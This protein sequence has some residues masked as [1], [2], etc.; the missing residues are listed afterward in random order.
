MA[1]NT[2]LHKLK[3][4]RSNDFTLGAVAPPRRDRGDSATEIRRHRQYFG[5]MLHEW[6]TVETDEGKIKRLQ[7]RFSRLDLESRLRLFDTY[8]SKLETHI[9]SGETEKAAVLQTFIEKI[10]AGLN[11]K[12]SS[13][14]DTSMGLSDATISHTNG[15]QETL[16]ENAPENQGFQ[17]RAKRGSKGISAAARRIIKSCGVIL[18]E[19]FRRPNLSLGTCTTPPVDETRQRQLCENWSEIKRQFFQALTRLLASRG[20]STDYVQVTEIQEKRFEKWGQVCP[21]LHF[22]FQ[23]RLHS[24][25]PWRVAPADIQ[26]LWQRSMENVL[27]VRLDCRSATRIENPR[28]SLSKE[29]GKYLT[30]G[31]K[32]V[33]EILDRGLGAYLPSSWYGASKALS[34]LERAA[35]IERTGEIATYVLRNLEALAESG[36]IKFRR[37]YARFKCPQTGIER[38]I[39]VGA[40]GWFTSRDAVNRVLALQFPTVRAVA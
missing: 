16:I 11:D 31:G 19:R 15:Q 4:S 5:W 35:R 7:S 27:G 1:T 8:E 20:L 2:K 34:L 36:E 29:L 9:N 39:C 12:D 13:E 32:V 28:K 22:V 30:K 40:S 14:V 6:L 18:E 23:G 24:R 10:V 25:E 26:F 21:H 37:I 33:K 3:I 17:R 38:E